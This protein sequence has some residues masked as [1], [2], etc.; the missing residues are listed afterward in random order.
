MVWFAGPQLT[1][2]HD[3]A[4]NVLTVRKPGVGIT[5]DWELAITL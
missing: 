3:T 1:Y 5:A 2:Y 4:T